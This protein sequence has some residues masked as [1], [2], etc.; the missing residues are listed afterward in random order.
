M[1]R[2]LYFNFFQYIKSS[3]LYKPLVGLLDDK[4]VKSSIYGQV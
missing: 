4:S 2:V 3:K 1:E